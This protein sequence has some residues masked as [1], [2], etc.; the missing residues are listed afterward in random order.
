MPVFGKLKCKEADFV[1]VVDLSTD[2]R[3]LAPI[4]RADL[5]KDWLH[6][7]TRE[8]NEAVDDLTCPLRDRPK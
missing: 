5:L 4:E 6:E 1:G 8:Y 2:F 7:I 3:A